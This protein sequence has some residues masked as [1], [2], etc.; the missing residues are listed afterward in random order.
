MAKQKRKESQVT[1]KK[2]KKLKKAAAREMPPAPAA[3]PGTEGAPPEEPAREPG[4]LR[5]EENQESPPDPAPPGVPPTRS[6]ARLRHRPAGWIWFQPS[7]AG[8]TCAV[9]GGCGGQEV[10][11]ARAHLAAW[12]AEVWDLR[13]G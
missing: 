8:L 9:R 11:R 12:D 6:A 5:Q 13:R 3:P 4:P 2:N 10:P 1:E 7:L